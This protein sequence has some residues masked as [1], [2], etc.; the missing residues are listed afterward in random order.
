[1]LNAVRTSRYQSLGGRCSTFRHRTRQRG[2]SLVE[3]LVVLSILAIL[4]A[5][6]IP[7]FAHQLQQRRVEALVYRFIADLQLARSAAVT[8][9]ARTTIAPTD[10]EHWDR[11]WQVFIDTN[12]DAA[13][14]AED[15]ILAQAPGVDSAL[16]IRGNASGQDWVSFTADGRPSL[17]NGSFQAGTFTMC[18]GPDLGTQVIM[19]RTGRVRLQAAGSAC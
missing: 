16:T 17:L 15:V 10:G 11:G 3:L 7:S 14:N 19:S 6:A 2:M 12:R 9:S 8:R 4:A 5:I 1:M 18:A 13:L